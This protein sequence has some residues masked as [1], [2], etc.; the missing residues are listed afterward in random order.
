MYDF[1]DWTKRKKIPPSLEEE[2]AYAYYWMK[3]V[4]YDLE[5]GASFHSEYGVASCLILLTLP[6]TIKAWTAV[7]D[8][9]KE[10]SFTT[11]VQEA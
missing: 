4:L 2:K 9:I 11:V 10:F 6:K 7:G 8:M 1:S 5:G 3:Q